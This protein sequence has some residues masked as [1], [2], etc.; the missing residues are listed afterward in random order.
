MRPL[1]SGCGR[2]YRRVAR[3]FPEEFRA[4]CGDGLEPFVVEAIEPPRPLGAAHGHRF[5]QTCGHRP[6]A[7]TR[8]DVPFDC[9]AAGGSQV[10][11]Q[12]ARQLHEQRA[13]AGG[14]PGRDTHCALLPKSFWSWM[15]ARCKRVLTLSSVIPITFA[16]SRVDK[17][18]ISRRKTM[19]R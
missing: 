6:T 12:V 9:S 5:S 17:P 3:A 7:R 1:V 13:T 15:R 18:S 19:A 4:V 2:L 8:L 10:A 16:T 14:G 11:I